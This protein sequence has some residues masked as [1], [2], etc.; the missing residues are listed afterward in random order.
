MDDTGHIDHKLS[1]EVLQ[2]KRIDKVS[3][4]RALTFAMQCSQAD[5]HNQDVPFEVADARWLAYDKAC[6]VWG[7]G[8]GDVGKTVE[9]LRSF[10][11]V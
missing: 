7:E 4:S 8:K 1:C 6:E 9:A 10:W 3:I 11:K 5:Q 2:G